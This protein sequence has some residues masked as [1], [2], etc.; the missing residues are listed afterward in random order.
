[1][2]GVSLPIETIVILVLAVIVL[3]A[4]LFFFTGIFG[5]SS[6]LVKLKQERSI[7]CGSYQ[8]S[9]FDCEEGEHEDV[10]E[11]IRIELAR[12]CSRLNQEEGGY[13]DCKYDEGDVAGHE[14]V[15]KC[16]SE[17]CSEA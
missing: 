1:M 8:R 10:D 5:P 12:I 15:K 16:C 7:W 2:K 13:P 3:V 6:S 17:F 4:L 11:N 9:N 14:C